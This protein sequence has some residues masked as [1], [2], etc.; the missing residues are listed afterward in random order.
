MAALTQQT[1]GS[2]P[3]AG[4]EGRPSL[5]GLELDNNIELATIGNPEPRAWHSQVVNVSKNRMRQ[6]FGRNPFKT[7][8]FSLYRPMRRPRDRFAIAGAVVL[9]ILAGLPLPII[10]I[11]FARIINQFPPQEDALR[12]HVSE[13]LGV[14]TGYFVVTAAYTISWGLIGEHISWTLRQAL[15]KRLLGLDQTYFDVEDPDIAGLLT[16][17]CESIQIGTSEKVGIFLQSISYFVAA[18]V[19]GFI[20]NAR[21]TAILFAAVIPSMTIIVTVGS[22]TV[23]K[24]ANRASE[25]TEQAGKL[26]ECC[27]SAVK[28]IQAFGMGN[29]MGKKYND[30]LQNAAAHAVR[31]STTSAIM[32]GS[33]YFVAYAANGLAFYEGSKMAAGKPR[34]N[35]GDIYAVVFLILDASFV[36]GQFGPFLGAFGTAA[37]AGEKVYEVLDFETPVI[38]AYSKDGYK[39]TADSLKR[40][41]QL[42][43]VS[44]AYPS[45]TAF[46]ALDG[47]DLSIKGGAMNA[48]V[49]ESGSGKSSIISLLLRLYDPSHGQ[50]LIDGHDMRDVNIASMRKHIALVDQEPV[51]FSGSILE[52]ISHG[53]ESEGLSEQAVLERCERAAAEA[54]VNFLGQL[55]Q[56][57]HTKVG[58]GGGAQLSGGQK[59]RICLARAL[60]KQ[61]VLLLLDEPTS[62]LDSASE[63]L[64]MTAIRSFAARGSTVVMVTH[65]LSTA[66]DFQ[67][68][69][70][71]SHGKVLEQGSHEDLISQGGIYKS[72]V[73]A[74]ALADTPSSEIVPILETPPS[75]MEPAPDHRL[76]EKYASKRISQD[77]KTGQSTERAKLG[78]GTILG[79]CMKLTRRHW[80][81]LGLALSLSVISGGIIVGEAITFGH[82]VQLLNLESN[83]AGFL[84][85]ASFLCLMFFMLAVIALIAHCGSGTCFGIASSYF[86]ARVQHVSL[87]NI[88]RQDMPWFAGR[89]AHSL[90]AGLSSDAAQLS[91][92]SGVAIG[93]VFSVTTSIS[94]GII[95]SHVVAWKIAVVLLCA[96]PVMIVSG[97]VRLRVLALSETR[98]RSAYNE[99]AAIA[100]EACGNMRTVAALG[101]ESKVF[102]LYRNSLKQPYQKGVRFTLTSNV[103]LAFS[104]AITYF[105]YALAYWWGS[106]QVRSGEYSTL[107]FFIVLPALLF[108]AQSAGQVFSLSPEISRASIA[109]RNVFTLHDEEPQI[110]SKAS[111]GNIGHRSSESLSS[112]SS[113]KSEKAALSKP[114]RKGSVWLQDVSLVYGGRKDGTALRDINLTIAPGEMVAVVGPSGAGKSSFIAL[115]ERF[116]DA[117]NGRLVIDGQDVRSIPVS[118]HRDRLGLVPQEP[119]LFPGSVLYNIR[120]GAVDGQTVTD[121]EIIAVCKECG[122]HEFIISLPEGYN[123][124]C[125]RNGS[126]LS[127]GQKQRI[128]IARALIRSPDILLLDEYTSALDAHSERDVKKA[129]ENAT[130]GRTTIVVAHRLST[131]QHANRIIVLDHGKI[132]EIGSHGELVSRGG[133]YASMVAAQALS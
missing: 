33:V 95:L 71:M 105:V 80:P 73:E 64:V 6:L 69:A 29:E 114:S 92:L 124:E 130:R 83:T 115:I 87:T 25:Y 46:K 59:Q 77:E 132:A 90:V 68:I 16:E 21:L 51:L 101:R 122:I 41:I 22:S 113:T 50:I 103:L 28:V 127:G 11:I 27:I 30:L 66:M 88:L 3:V 76:A 15:V 26:A 107:Q 47:V 36:L 112:V 72:M 1:S 89:S 48:L 67:N 116:Y 23:T 97:Y 60:V 37:A 86:I 45:R 52:N 39:L 109:A 106:R 55:P 123:T 32:L 85:R 35:A 111:Y 118:K 19:V 94:G 61:P 56:G 62:A 53:L 40:T 44:F 38:D 75:E 13:L 24:F 93:T 18:F 120:L 57:I 79:R 42:K 14:G 49:G 84:G 100:S 31:K 9:A 96:V 133:I 7:S 117:S 74:Q 63:T 119:D 129:V 20:L 81:L 121:E 108:S 10:G 12:K 99:A 2:A 82:V 17:K 58:N 34:G 126:K 125:G 5:A 131:V 70:L 102:Q 91:C 128:A 43:D 110:M 78:V 54:N 104:F 4:P 65:R 8:Y 98:H